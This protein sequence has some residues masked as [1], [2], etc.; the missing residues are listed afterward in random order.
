MIR[1][2]GLH[3]DVRKILESHLVHRNNYKL[4]DNNCD[5]ILVNVHDW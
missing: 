1:P 5:Y 3:Q 4:G 2:S